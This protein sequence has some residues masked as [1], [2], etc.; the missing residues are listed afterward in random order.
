MSKFLHICLN[1]L[2]M[3]Q[4][5]RSVR[6]SLKTGY[7]PTLKKNRCGN[8]VYNFFNGSLA[9]DDAEQTPYLENN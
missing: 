2:E 8:S 9:F 5:S 1:K 4:V 7:R 6:I 3:G